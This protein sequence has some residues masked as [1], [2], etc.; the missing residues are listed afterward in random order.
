MTH[1]VQRFLT[2][3]AAPPTLPK[4]AV[5]GFDGVEDFASEM[6]RCYNYE[7]FSC[8]GCVNDNQ[9]CPYCGVTLGQLRIMQVES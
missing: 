5:C 2:D 8:E 9:H 1:P 3:L 6:F 7:E 4:L